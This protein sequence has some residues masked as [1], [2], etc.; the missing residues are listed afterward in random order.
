MLVLVQFYCR[1]GLIIQFVISPV[2]LTRT[3]WDIPPLKRKPRND[4]WHSRT[5]KSILGLVPSQ[6][7]SLQTITLSYSCHACTI[8]TKVS[9]AGYWLFRI[10]IWKSIRN[11]FLKCVGWCFV[12]ARSTINILFVCTV[13][14]FVFGYKT[15]QV[16]SQGEGC[17][18]CRPVCSLLPYS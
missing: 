12:S 7:F 4:C 13:S 2:S 1:R 10:L 5:L 6:L 9:C 3:R 11:G 15:L 14:F 17:N 18:G 16:L 8:R